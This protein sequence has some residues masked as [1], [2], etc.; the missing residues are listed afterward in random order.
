MAVYLFI[1]FISFIV[2]AFLIVPFINLL[3]RLKIQ[4]ASQV[5][6]D[7]FNKVSQIFDKFH[8]HK[9][10]TPVGGGLLLVVTTILLF[11]ISMAWFAAID[12]TIITNYPSITSEIKILLF[13]FISFSF[14]GLYDDLKKIFFWKQDSFFGLRLR[15]KFIIEVILA[16]IVAYWLYTE[17]NV[18]IVNIPFFGVFDM[19]WLYL[20]FV[21]FV[22]VSFANAVNIT[23]GL[24]GL[25]SGSLIIARANKTRRFKP[26]DK[27][28]T[29]CEPSKSS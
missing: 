27:A 18:S 2:N 24:D 16:S 21:V 11:L 26:P 5:T 19:G 29:A 15:Y 3:Y 4:R 9:A 13:T 12:K 8:R 22:I 17:L 14:L 23:D 20:V 10:G 25:S 1:F 28:L 7:A 6:L